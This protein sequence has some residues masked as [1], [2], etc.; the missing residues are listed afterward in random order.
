MKAGA[1]RRTLDC[2]GCACSPC[3]CGLACAPSSGGLPPSRPDEQ[4]QEP[5]RPRVLPVDTLESFQLYLETQWLPAKLFLEHAAGIVV[6][7]EIESIRVFDSPECVTIDRVFRWTICGD[8]LSSVED[9]P[10]SKRPF[11]HNQHLV[12]S[13]RETDNREILSEIALGRLQHIR[14]ARFGQRASATEESSL[15]VGRPRKAT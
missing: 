9:R 8:V 2:L 1:A 4:L 5:D 15:A 12:K 10:P 11:Q 3:R 6:E 14:A 7:L 13:F